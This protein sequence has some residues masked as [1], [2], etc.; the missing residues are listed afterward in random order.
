MD[1]KDSET[2]SYLVRMVTPMK[3]EFG[4]ALDVSQFLESRP[5]AVEVIQQALQSK[6][7]RLREYAEYVQGKF[8]GPRT[9]NSGR[10]KAQQAD[11]NP[12]TAAQEREADTAQ[13]KA[14]AATD[15]ELRARML[16]KYKSGLR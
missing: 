2:M 13:I 3:R 5:Y 1:P 10:S 14:A 12:G 4:R 16:A 11:P 9:G 15:T 7:G 8:F 6:D